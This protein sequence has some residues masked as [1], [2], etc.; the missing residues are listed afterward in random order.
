VGCNDAPLPSS[1]STNHSLDFIPARWQVFRPVE[2]PGKV[3][4][5][6]SS[7]FSRWSQF[8]QYTE[9]LFCTLTR[10]ALRR[11]SSGVSRFESKVENREKLILLFSC[12]HYELCQS[13]SAASLERVISLV[14]T[15]PLRPLSQATMS[16][17]VTEGSQPVAQAEQVEQEQQEQGERSQPVRTRSRPWLTPL[18]VVVARAPPP[19]GPSFSSAP[20]PRLVRRTV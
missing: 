5:S 19:I 8:G 16:D 11:S 1:T 14:L 12:H 10:E 4:G 3:D 2:K 17:E 9:R 18:V 15:A 20:I 13:P 7:R 6:L